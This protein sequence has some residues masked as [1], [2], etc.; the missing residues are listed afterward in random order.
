MSLSYETDRLLRILDGHAKVYLTPAQHP[1]PLAIESG[2]DVP[3]V[4]STVLQV[5]ES[6]EDEFVQGFN[7][8]KAKEAELEEIIE[9]QRRRILELGG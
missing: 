8:W 3:H 1:G 6:M 9:S 7:S 5:I 2:Y 4:L